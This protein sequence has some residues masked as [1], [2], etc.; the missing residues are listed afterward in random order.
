MV[1][2][3]RNITETKELAHAP[4]SGPK[5]KDRRSEV[6]L[7]RGDAQIWDNRQAMGDKPVV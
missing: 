3:Q 5:M 2:A 1:G 6:K 4:W 7:A